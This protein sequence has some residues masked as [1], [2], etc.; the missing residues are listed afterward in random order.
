MTLYTGLRSGE[1]CQIRGEWLSEEN[2]ETW[3]TIPAQYMKKPQ[4]GDHRVPL[5]GKALAISDRRGKS[6]LWFPSRTGGAVKQKVVGIDVYAHS[7]RSKAKAYKGYSVCP[8]KE[9]WAPND[10]RKTAR[11]K[12]A[13]LGCPFE[14]AESIL[15][16]RVAGVA[17]LYN[18]H[19]YD[20]EKRAWLLRYAEYLNQFY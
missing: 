16:H 18:R 20:K 14:V 4:N 8:V 1:A 7:G 12:L 15:H 3:L 13:E 11:T 2:G 19:Q 9:P 5:V 6:G 10:L 17:G